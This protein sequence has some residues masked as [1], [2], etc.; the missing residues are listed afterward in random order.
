[1]STWADY[2][3]GLESQTMGGRLGSYLQQL[4]VGP[5]SYMNPAVRATA[6]NWFDPMSSRYLLAAAPGDMGGYSGWETG[7][8]V[9]GQPTGSTF[10]EYLQQPLT[11]GRPGY[12]PTETTPTPWQ[13]GAPTGDTTTG[14]G[15]LQAFQ[16]WT[17]GQW[18]GRLGAMNLPGTAA[19]LTQ[20]QTDYLGMLSMPETQSMIG[21]ATM[22]GMNPIAQRAYR[23]GLSR[24]MSAWQM[25]NPELGAG[26][27]LRQF[28]TGGFTDA[29]R[30][31]PYMPGVT[32]AGTTPQTF[33]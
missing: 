1:M 7:A 27:L 14:A 4:D 9:A 32:A 31:T 30:T 13:Y 18:A 11:F 3:R 29:S 26:E 2:I 12:Q 23:P 28:A 21:S 5:L 16:P 24:A 20:E 6:R 25:A 19:G 22:A 17:R 33:L 15:Y 10:A 8:N